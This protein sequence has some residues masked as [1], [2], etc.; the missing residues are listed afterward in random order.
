MLFGQLKLLFNRLTDRL[1]EELLETDCPLVARMR[2]LHSE[3]NVV[4]LDDESFHIGRSI[5]TCVHD[6]QKGHQWRR[7]WFIAHY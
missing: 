4:Y 7:R 3:F 5:D 1:K 2:Q 6:V